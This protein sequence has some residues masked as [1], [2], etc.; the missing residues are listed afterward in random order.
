M[1]LIEHFQGHAQ[2]QI[3]K[4]SINDR[5]G[6]VFVLPWP[7]LGLDN[8]F[9]VK[10]FFWLTIRLVGHFQINVNNYL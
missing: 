6:F 1:L 8:D 5:N 9:F 3:Y 7:F 10:K 4:T 2:G